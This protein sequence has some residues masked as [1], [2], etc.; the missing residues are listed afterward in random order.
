[1]IVLHVLDELRPSGAEAMLLSAAPLWSERT[2][3]HILTTG[4]SEGSFAPALRDAGYIIHHLPFDRSMRFFRE[5]ARVVEDSGCDVLHLHTERASQWYALAAR[6][7]CRRSLRVVR[8]VHH[9]FRFEGSLR[10]RRMFG[11]QF[12]KRVLW[13]SFLSNSPSGQRN[14]RKRF[15]MFN[16]LVPNWYDSDYFV[17]ADD[18]ER[19]QARRSLGFDNETTVFVSLGGNW[20]YK[21]YDMIVESLARIPAGHRLCYI[22]IGVQGEGDPLETLAKSLEVSDRLRCVGVVMNVRS[23]LYA[24]DAYL[25]PSSEEGFGVA[26][27]E[28]MASGLPAILSDVEALSDFRENLDGICYIDPTPSAIAEAMT[29]FCTMPTES[30]QQ[31]GRTLAR[32][33]E[34]HYGLAVG[35]VAYLKAW[36]VE[37]NATQVE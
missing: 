2:E 17:P 28:A 3:Q 25:M 18:A 30:L 8:T 23:Y 21:N 33:V 32:D 6:L 7:F 9:L 37:E 36:G 34:K 29:S 31:L 10:F 26:A 19:R 15:R 16:E 35:P 20:S 5:F 12:M 13:V 27:V 1:M 24:A 4:N 14:E 22:Q 11:R